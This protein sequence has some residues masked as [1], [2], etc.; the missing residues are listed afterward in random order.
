MNHVKLGECADI[1]T[2]LVLKRKE[3]NRTDKKKYSYKTITLRSLEQEGWMNEEFFDKFKSSEKLEDRYLTQIGDVIIRLSA[4][5]TAI[6][7]RDSQLGIVIP[8][9]CAIIRNKSNEIIPGYLAFLLN[10]DIMKK[11]YLR[12]SLGATIPVIRMADLKETKVPVLPIEMQNRTID[13]SNLIIIEKKL[14][15]QLLESKELLYKEITNKILLGGIK[16][17]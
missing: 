11:E 3:A 15:H 17:D 10:S 6:A 1:S 4:P 13:V 8:S 2:G 14:Y 9:L 16:N 12:S 7:V 5:Y